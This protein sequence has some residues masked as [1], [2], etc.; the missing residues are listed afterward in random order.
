MG[1][2]PSPHADNGN[3][4]DQARSDLFLVRIWDGKG[5]EGNEG[6]DKAADWQGKIQHVVSGKTYG[7]TGRQALLDMIGDMLA[8]SADKER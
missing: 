8:G 1:E 2:A 7:F 3:T 6:N 5:E 4:G